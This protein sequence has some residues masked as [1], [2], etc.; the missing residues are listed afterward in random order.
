MYASVKYLAFFYH[1][2]FYVVF[3]L[4]FLMQKCISL[5]FSIY[6]WFFMK[7]L[8]TS[9]MSVAIGQ[10]EF[11]NNQS[12]AIFFTNSFGTSLMSAAIGQFEFI[13]NQSNARVWDWFL[14]NAIFNM[15]LWSKGFILQNKLIVSSHTNLVLCCM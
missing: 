9:L 14:F 12:N 8:G 11:I 10:F 15:R 6:F 4:I 2:S 3:Y 5:K 7:N 13:S 1:L